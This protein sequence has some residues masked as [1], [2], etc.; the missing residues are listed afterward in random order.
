MWSGGVNVNV[1]KALF[2]LII[3]AEFLLMNAKEVEDDI[4]V[5][6]SSVS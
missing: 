2:S 4:S 5:L 6:S 3:L 1:G